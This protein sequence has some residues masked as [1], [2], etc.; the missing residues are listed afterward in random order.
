ML[1][2][3]KFNHLL[4]SFSLTRD[5]PVPVTHCVVWSPWPPRTNWALRR[6]VLSLLYCSS[7]AAIL[8]PSQDSRGA[9]LVFHIIAQWFDSKKI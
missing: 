9:G 8:R 4:I 1:F 2:Q 6:C 3:Y 7:T 5:L